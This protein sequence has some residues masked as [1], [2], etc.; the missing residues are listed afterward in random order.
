MVLSQKNIISAIG[1][2]LIAMA[3]AF[4]IFSKDDTDIEP[5]MKILSDEPRYSTYEFPKDS[6]IIKFGTQPLYIPTGLISETIK[7]DMIL[8]RAL[9]EIGMKLKFYPF[10]KGDDINFFLDRGHLDIGISGDMPTLKAA[11]TSDIIITNLVQKGFTS[12]VAKKFVLMDEL[13][14]KRIGYAFGSN[15]HYSLLQALT[16]VG[17]DENDVHL[18]AMDVYEMPKR[19]NAGD[20]YAF[21][22][23]EPTPSIVLKQQKDAAI[24]HRNLNS[25]Y[26]YFW[27]GFSSDHNIATEYIVA[28]TIRA[29][30][31]IQS[32]NENLL[33]ASN[34][35]KKASEKLTGTNLEISAEEIAELAKKDILGMR[36]PS[37]IHESSL[38]K[39]SSLY[40]EFE[41]LKTVGKIP[42]STDWEQMRKSFDI[43]IAKNILAEPLKYKLN[44]YDY[45]GQGD[46]DE[47]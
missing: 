21:S 26:L 39:E 45:T 17:L 9:S 11:A 31:W 35:S 41:F 24:I 40:K 13:R 10:L 25:G 14:R 47:Q 38:D 43:E 36:Q 15:A 22:A 46:Q 4:F 30:H 27:G 16:A 12:I 3:I 32:S 29:I 23:W 33:A 8:K 20:I 42:V 19:L 1:I 2:L 34:W 37:H 28:A 7:R 44:E 6:T 18:V 5:L